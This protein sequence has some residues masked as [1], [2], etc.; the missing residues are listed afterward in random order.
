MFR[1]YL[2]RSFATCSSCLT[3][4]QPTPLSA[5]TEIKSASATA[6][7]RRMGSFWKNIT[8]GVSRKLSVNARARGMR[9][10]RAKYRINTIPART[11]RGLSVGQSCLGRL[12]PLKE[13]PKRG[14]GNRRSATLDVGRA[15]VVRDRFAGGGKNALAWTMLVPPRDLHR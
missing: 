2:G 1:R 7:T 9:I 10:A 14:W 15:V 8:N 12:I 11:T 4:T 6:G 13:Y 5:A 3:T